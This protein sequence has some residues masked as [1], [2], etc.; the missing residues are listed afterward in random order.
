M[1]GPGVTFDRGD[2]MG[3]FR[4]VIF[5]ICLAPRS[6]SLFVH[7]G[8]D[9][10]GA[11]GA[12]V[13]FLKNL[14]R[15][16]GNHD[17]RAVVD[18]ASAQVPRIEMPGDYYQLLR[19]FAALKVANYVVAGLV[20][21]FLRRQRKVHTYTALPENM[22]DQ[23]GIFGGNRA[24]GDAPPGTPAGMRQAAIGGAHRP[25]PTRPPAPIPPP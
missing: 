23:V 17:T 20:G 18:G 15:L 14:G 21:E 4:G 22:R 6:S 9:A 24:G 12:Q 8:N 2:M 10:Q 11:L 1:R 25:R 13:Q 5:G 16:H 19:M 7:P 3:E